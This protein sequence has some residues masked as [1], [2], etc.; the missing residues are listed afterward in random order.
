MKMIFSLLLLVIASLYV[1]PV[2][3]AFANTSAVC[4]TDMEEE[5]DDIKNKEKIK[6]LFSFSNSYS[7]IA[8]DYSCKH[9]FITFSIPVLLNTVETPPPDFV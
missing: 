1:L 8:D 2:K 4:M 6:E 7:I 3:E 9:Q 5:K